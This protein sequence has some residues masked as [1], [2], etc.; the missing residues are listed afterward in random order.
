MGWKSPISSA[1]FWLAGGG[2]WKTHTHIIYIYYNNPQLAGPEGVMVCSKFLV[3]AYRF[4]RFLSLE[5]LHRGCLW[6]LASMSMCKKND[7]NHAPCCPAKHQHLEHQHEDGQMHSNHVAFQHK[8]AEPSA[9]IWKH[10]G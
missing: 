1:L 9:R 10:R 2:G 8:H 3:H 4:Q 5:H 7:R 6:I